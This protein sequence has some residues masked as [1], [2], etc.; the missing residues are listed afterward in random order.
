LK[1]AAK[2]A[3]LAAPARLAGARRIGRSRPA[4]FAELAEDLAQPV[5][6]CL[7]DGR[8]LGQVHVLERGETADG[9]V[10]AGVTGGGE[11]RPNPFGFHHVSISF[12]A[13]V[14]RMCVMYATVPA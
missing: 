5:V 2:L 13:L 6:H 9:R 4:R 11:S 1:G 7:E 12:S 3:L 8:P 14:T 10:D